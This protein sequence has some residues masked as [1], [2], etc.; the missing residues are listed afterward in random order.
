MNF[1]FQ[2]H[3]IRY[4]KF[5]H[6]ANENSECDD[7]EPDYLDGLLDRDETDESDNDDFDGEGE[8]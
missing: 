8:I 6:V 2:K 4:E 1:L 3:N 7:L 5:S